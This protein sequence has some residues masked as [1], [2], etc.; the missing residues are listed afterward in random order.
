M[1][2]ERQTNSTTT[3]PRLLTSEALRERVKPHLALASWRNWLARAIALH[4]FPKGLRLGERTVSFR[5]DEVLAWLEARERGGRFDGKRPSAP[6]R[7]A[8]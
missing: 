5:E 3:L 2:T 1:L 4:G 6:P 7:E 8:A